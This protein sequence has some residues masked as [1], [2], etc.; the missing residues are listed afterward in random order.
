MERVWCGGIWGD[1][2][3]HIPKWATAFSNAARS[4]PLFDT[5][6]VT[7][8]TRPPWRCGEEEKGRGHTEWE[9][10]RVAHLFGAC[11]RG[12]GDI[13][14]AP[15]RDTRKTRPKRHSSH[16]AAHN[17]QPSPS[18]CAQGV[19]FTSTAEYALSN[20]SGPSASLARRGGRS[21]ST[22]SAP[23]LAMHSAMPSP[24]PCTCECARF[25]CV[26]VCVRLLRQ[27]YVHCA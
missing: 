4:C 17:C 27:A 19:L 10:G 16:R 3:T 5:S 7:T 25:E 11:V 26:H 9:G 2:I 12:L 21:K 23:A 20:R 8:S 14:F 1:T 24:M 13:E 15:A 6:A 22:M 18:Q